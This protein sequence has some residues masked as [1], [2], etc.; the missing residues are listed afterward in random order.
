MNFPK[1]S[2]IPTVSTT[3]LGLT[4][5][6]GH[7][8]QDGKASPHLPEGAL[9]P[10]LSPMNFSNTN[11]SAWP[12]SYSNPMPAARYILSHDVGEL[13]HRIDAAKHWGSAR[14]ANGEI[15]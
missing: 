3:L 1:R 10:S 14:R 4:L 6:L 13:D 12:G 15:V 2:F 9:P 11:V 8:T 5:E 7:T